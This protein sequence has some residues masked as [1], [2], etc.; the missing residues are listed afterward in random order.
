MSIRKK[1]HP[2][3]IASEKA[4]IEAI[5]NADHFL[6]SLFRGIGSYEKVEAPTVLRALQMAADLEA[7]SCSTKRCMI[8]AVAHDGHSTLVTKSLIERLKV[9][10][11]KG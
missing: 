1:Q 11:S 10:S 7:R 8:Y 6:A 9:K 5:R 3:D 2:A 4:M